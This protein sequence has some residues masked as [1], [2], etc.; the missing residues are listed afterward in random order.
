ML[1]GVEMSGFGAPFS[2][3]TPMPELAI[4]RVGAVGHLAALDQAVDA[5][6]RRDQQVGGLAVGHALGDRAG[7]R[8]D[9][10]ELVAGRLEFRR[11][12]VPHFGER[13]RGQHLQF[14]GCRE[15]G[16]R[17]KRQRN[18]ASE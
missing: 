9:D 12:L 4:E 11:E 15:T 5:G 18:R 6:R 14:G 7:R 17:G 10:G 16:L 1:Q 2:T 8:I 13:R 3:A